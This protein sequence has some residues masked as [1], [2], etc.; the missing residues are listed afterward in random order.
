MDELSKLTALLELAEK[1]GIIVRQAPA[2]DSSEHPGGALIRLGRREMLFL[3]PSAPTGD[4]L[5]AAA[6]ALRGRPELEEM[7]LPPDIRELLET[8]EHET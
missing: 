5:G 1:V 3:D 4:Q 6:A 2:S 7:F 8:N